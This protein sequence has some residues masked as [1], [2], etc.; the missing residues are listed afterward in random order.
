[1]VLVIHVV[2]ANAIALLLIDGIVDLIIMNLIL[3][4]VEKRMFRRLGFES[5][6]GLILLANFLS[7]FVAFHVL[8][9]ASGFTISFPDWL[10]SMEELHGITAW[11]FLLKACAAIAITLLTEYPI[12][13]IAIKDK[14]RRRELMQPFVMVNL[15][16]SLM[17]ILFFTLFAALLYLRQPVP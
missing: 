3:A 4:W 1:M 12:T 7:V 15:A 16:T 5:R 8:P 9:Y 11:D 13:R 6:Y 17:V 10:F 14:T 2:I